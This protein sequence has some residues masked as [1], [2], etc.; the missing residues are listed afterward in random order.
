MPG[1]INTDFNDIK[2]IMEGAGPALRY[3]HCR[4]DDRAKEYAHEQSP[5]CRVS[6]LAR[7][8]SFVVAGSDDLGIMEVRAKVINESVDKNAKVIFGIMRDES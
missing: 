5:H 1:E 4:G 8:E 6:I 2:A 3:R 7:K